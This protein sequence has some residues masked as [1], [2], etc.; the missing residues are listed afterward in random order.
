VLYRA[1]AQ[2]R[3]FEES[4]GKAQ[5]P[6]RI[7]G[8]VGFYER[9][10]IRD[11]IAYL[12]LLVNR[13]DPLSF[14]RIINVPP[15]GVGKKMLERIQV[16]ADT[17]KISLFDAAARIGGKSLSSFLDLFERLPEKPSIYMDDLLTRIG[18]FDYLRK[19]DPL[20]AEE[21]IENISEFLAFLRENEASP[22]FDLT[23]FLSELP[24]QSRAE[25]GADGV[26]LLT[27]HSAKGLEFQHLF[28]VGLEEGLFPHIR[29]LDKA[30]DVEEERRLFYV[31]MTRAKQ[32]L[33]LSWAQRRGMFGN[34][35]SNRPSRFLDEIP[36]WFKVN[37]ISERFGSPAVAATTRGDEEPQEFRSGSV[38]SHAKFG[39]GTVVKVEG[40]KND[41][42]LTIR[43]ND[44]V[45]TILTR[46]AQ[47]TLLSR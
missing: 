6:H 16:E 19:D 17:Q 37:R 27:V 35:M 33:T 31:A 28:V 7:V 4:F 25:Q 29:S 3:A 47:I 46:Y 32:K 9:R 11:A 1:N 34:N 44:G 26:T 41:W 15:R 38:V 40:V 5:I 36:G 23:V 14:Y 18:Y 22:E 42:K 43:F 39:R 12:R 45:K 21:R 2:S 20:T 8:G 30:E 13:N 10:E 24:L